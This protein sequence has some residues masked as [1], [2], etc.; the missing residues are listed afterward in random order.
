MS[1]AW[2]ACEPPC[3]FTK[4][5]TSLRCCRESTLGSENHTVSL[6]LGHFSL[7][8]LCFS[9]RRGAKRGPK[10][11]E[12]AGERAPAAGPLLLLSSAFDKGFKT[13]GLQT[14]LEMAF[15]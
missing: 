12:R 15:F 5:S 1:M 2:L 7:I 9:S 10:S 4:P 6:I 14:G 3:A 8:L 11:K 13:S